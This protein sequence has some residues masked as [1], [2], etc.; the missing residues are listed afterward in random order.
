M[1]RLEEM[2]AF[3][4][5]RHAACGAMKQPHSQMLLELRQRLARGLRRH[6]LRGRGLPQAAEFGRLHEGGN[7]TQLVDR[8]RVLFKKIIIK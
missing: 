4:G 8:H 2:T 1:R 5:Q 3:I 6:A 7:G